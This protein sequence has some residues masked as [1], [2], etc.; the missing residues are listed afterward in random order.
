MHSY[1]WAHTLSF[2][3]HVPLVCS[4]RQRFR[5]DTHFVKDHLARKYQNQIQTWI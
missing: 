3:P 4:E 2:N 1:L 5:E